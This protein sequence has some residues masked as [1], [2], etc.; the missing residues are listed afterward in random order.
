MISSIKVCSTYNKTWKSI[1]SQAATV[2]FLEASEKMMKKSFLEA[3]YV[4]AKIYHTY[5]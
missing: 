3:R 1:Q 2:G 5:A 4:A